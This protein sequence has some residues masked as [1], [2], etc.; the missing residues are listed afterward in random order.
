MS[1]C[2]DKRQRSGNVTEKRMVEAA[3]AEQPKPELVEQTIAM[4]YRTGGVL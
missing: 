4:L 3:R 1:K 2:R